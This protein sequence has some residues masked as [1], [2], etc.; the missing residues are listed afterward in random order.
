MLD[1][2]VDVFYFEAFDESWKP[3]ATGLDGQQEDETSWGAYSAQRVAK[4]DLSC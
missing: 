4:F 2:G 1:W 3:P